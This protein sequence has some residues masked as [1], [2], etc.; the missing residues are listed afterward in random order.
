ML[1]DTGVA[2]HPN[3]ARFADLVGKSV[4]VPLTDRLV[5]IV[6]DEHADPETGSGVVKITPAHDFADFEV[7]RRHGLA[8]INI[9]DQ[10]A[11]LTDAVPAAYRG[12]DRFAAREK[13]VADLASAGLLDRVE[14]HTLMVP[15][16][17]RS[18]VVIEP[19]L[20]DQWYCD[21]RVLA[22]PALA[23]VEDGRTWFVPRQWENTFFDWMRKIQP[24][25]ISR[26]L[27]WGH[28]IPAWYEPDGA[29]FVAETEEEAR[30]QATEKH[31]KEIELRRD[32]DVLDTWFS[33]ALWP[34]STL[35]WPEPTRE[36]ARYYPTDVLV[37]GFDI[38]FFWVAR[39]MMMGLHFMGDVPFHTVY[40]HALVRDAR[41]RKMSKSRGNI[42]DPLELIDRYGCDALRLT[43]A[44]LAA[45]GRD[46]KLSESR[47]E[48]YRNFAT[49]LWNAARYA[50]MN[51][52]ALVSSFAPADCELTVNRWI[53]AAV[54]DCATAVTAALDTYRFDEAVNRLYHFVWGSFCD[55]YLEFTKPI[56]QSEDAAARAET[57]ATTAWIL[58]RILHLLHPIMPFITEEVW[59]QL[60]GQSPGMLI[61]ARWPEFQRNSIDPEASAEMEWVVQAISA[62]R[63]LRAEMNVPP[64]ARVPLLIKDAESVAAQRIKKHREHFVRLARVERFEPVESLPPGGVQVVIEGATLILAL[65]QVVDIPKERERLGKEI[66]KMDAELA[67]IGAKL[68]NA[69]FLAKAKP[70][71]IEEQRERQIDVT[72]DR[73]RLRAAYDRLTAG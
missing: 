24:W 63:A 6:A 60:A 39:M 61:T 1:G 53:S 51:G 64:A 12:L 52:C 55:W 70:E 56:L 16:H 25:C 35:G 31:G 42:I 22:A 15:H 26:Q 73:D 13:V 9:F 47:I 19:W 69:N 72:R 48:G 44:A 68:A 2:V 18:G 30:Q 62:I 46:I 34:F 21:A 20:T 58:S 54:A 17:D 37:T 50:Q 38:I 36:L 29:V 8:L 71:V 43:L 66:R 7:G 67:K 10:D 57:Q 33:S 27:W 23:A 4:R 11:R 14:E 3:D 45:P 49:K 40:I 65:G 5:P 41:G 28:Q 32:T 59:E